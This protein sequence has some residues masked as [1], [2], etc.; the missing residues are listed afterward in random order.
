VTNTENNSEFICV[1]KHAHAR[2]TYPPHVKYCFC[3]RKKYM[4]EGGK[5]KSKLAYAYL[6]QSS[7]KSTWISVISFRYKSCSFHDV[8]R[9][10]DI[11]SLRIKGTEVMSCLLKW[12]V[13]IVHNVGERTCSYCYIWRKRWRE[14]NIKIVH[15]EANLGAWREW[16]WFLK[17]PHESVC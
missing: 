11:A 7:R 13:K 8:Y 4:F 2:R 12:D 3:F 15:K 16:N 14:D 1:Y 17:K 10:S 9:S 6:K 5:K